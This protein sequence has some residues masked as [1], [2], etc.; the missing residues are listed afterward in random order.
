MST[1]DS[2]LAEEGAEA[3]LPVAERPGTGVLRKGIQVLDLIARADSPL[4]FTELVRKSGLPKGTLH[5]IVATLIDAGFVRIDEREQ[6][7]VLGMRLFEMAHIVWDRFDLRGAA[8]PELERMRDSTHETVRLGILEGQTVIYVDQREAQQPVRLA[9]GVGTRVQ[10]HA[11]ATGKAILAHLPPAEQS[12]LLAGLGLQALTPN[13]IRDVEELRRQ[14]DIA[15]ARG[16]ALSVDEQTP[17]VS[18]VAAPILDH[19]GR[20]LGAISVTGP[21][22]RLTQNQLHPIGRDLIEAARRIA[23]YAGEPRMSISPK[24]RPL[25][26]ERQDVICAIPGTAFLGEGPV[27]SARDERLYWVDILAPAVHWSDLTSDTY[28]TLAMNE[29]VSAVLPRRRGGL[30][31]LTQSG[32]KALDIRT[33]EVTL[34]ADPESDKPAN[35]FNDAKV[36]RQGRL[37]AGT[38]ALDTSPHQGALWCLDT[39]GQARCMD[40]G[41]TISNGMGWSPD[42]KVFYFADSGSGK[43]HAYDFDAARGDIS[44]RRTFVEVDSEDGRP[45]GLT[46]DAEGYVWVAHWDGWCVT[47]YDPDGTVERVINLPVP[48][49]ASCTFGGPDFTTLYVTSARIRLSAQ[50]LSEAPLS[51]SVFAIETG[52]RGLAEPMFGG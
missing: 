24:P 12:A 47:R 13:T 31:A 46:V 52:V 10:C 14:L 6:T 32:I 38:L 22:Y 27:W 26:P 19:A 30:V 50:R 9:N 41:F 45:D 34:L 20:P 44:G 1:S 2:E 18:S 37:W 42:D 40:H 15:K 33:G 35:R 51:G 5:R 39:D 3:D 25:G 11:S 49:P 28:E 23:G 21:S 29:L 48:R 8:E 36:D 43:I 7:Y 17:G 16:Y 4:K